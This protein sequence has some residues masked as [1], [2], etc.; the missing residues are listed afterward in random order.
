MKL[1]QILTVSLLV[2]LA[3]CS[4]TDSTPLATKAQFTA[5]AGMSGIRMETGRGRVPLLGDMLGSGSYWV[6]TIDGKD[7][8]KF[9]KSGEGFSLV[10]AGKHEIGLG[11]ASSYLSA[12]GWITFE[13]KP[14]RAYLAYVKHVPRAIEFWI[15]DAESGEL[16]AE[17]YVAS[18]SNK[19]PLIIP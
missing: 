1:F 14:G 11:W 16:V 2:T 9:G 15:V 18:I 7:R 3:G 10:P 13:L 8:R 12:F 4:T 6:D 19:P 5:Q 17:K